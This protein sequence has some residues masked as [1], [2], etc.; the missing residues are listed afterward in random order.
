MLETIQARRG[1][2]LQA[3]DADFGRIDALIGA[4][5]ALIASALNEILGHA[6]SSRLEASWSALAY[7]VERLDA[8]RGGRGT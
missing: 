6:E 4:I 3:S 5:D 8:G 2:I 1:S 7:L